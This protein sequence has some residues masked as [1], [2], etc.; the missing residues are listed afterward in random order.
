MT[1]YAPDYSEEVQLPKSGTFRAKIVEVTQK[2]SQAGNDYLNWKLEVARAEGHFFVFHRTMLSGKGAGFLK[3]F[4]QA[5]D[6]GYEG[7]EFDAD[8]LIGRSIS[9]DLVKKEGS[10]FLAVGSVEADDSPEP[11]P[12]DDC[13]F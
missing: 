1:R 6:P 4:I 11:F 5:V 13:P 10:D 2:T 9:V 12:S 7:G 3:R 8:S